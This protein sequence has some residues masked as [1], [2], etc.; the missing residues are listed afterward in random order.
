MG[1]WSPL[2]EDVLLKGSLCVRV[3]GSD[4]SPLPKRRVVV[5]GCGFV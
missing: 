2:E 5:R 3:V 4:G 1:D